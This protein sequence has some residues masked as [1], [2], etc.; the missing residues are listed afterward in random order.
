MIIKVTNQDSFAN[1][2]VDEI[3]RSVQK[4]GRNNQGGAVYQETPT[5]PVQPI[6]KASNWY[7][8]KSLQL[9]SGEWVTPQTGSIIEY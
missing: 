9:Q 3:N 5:S 1:R 8:Q 2:T 7:G 6:T 4:P